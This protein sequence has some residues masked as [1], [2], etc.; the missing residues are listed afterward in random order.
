VFCP[1]TPAVFLPF[2]S[3][4]K[5]SGTYIFYSLSLD[6]PWAP[7]VNRWIYHLFWLP[8]PAIILLSWSYSPPPANQFIYVYTTSVSH[9]SYKS[10]HHTRGKL[11][12]PLSVCSPW[13]PALT[14]QLRCPP[15]GRNKFFIFISVLSVATCTYCNTVLSSSVKDSV[16]VTPMMNRPNVV[17]C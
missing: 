11:Y 15:Y 9:Q 2:F 3:L 6:C 10:V 1:S 14:V 7:D 13:H 4:N 16:E 5:H 8:P 17:S 12:F